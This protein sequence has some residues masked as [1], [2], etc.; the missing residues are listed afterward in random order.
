MYKFINDSERNSMIIWGIDY[1]SYN[2]CFK[3]NIRFIRLNMNWGLFRFFNSVL[4]DWNF[5]LEDMRC[6][7]YD[8]FK[9]L[10]FK[11]FEF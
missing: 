9:I 10:L 6:L 2:I 3:E 1:Y 11:F 7:F 4:I 8:V 5:F